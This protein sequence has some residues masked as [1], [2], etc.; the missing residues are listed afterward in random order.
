MSCNVI[1]LVKI[2]EQLAT[3]ERGDVMNKVKNDVIDVKFT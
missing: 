3:L 1:A 2:T